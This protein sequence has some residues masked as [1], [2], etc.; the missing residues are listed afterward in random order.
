MYQMYASLEI[1]FLMEE[2]Q[3]SRESQEL[4]GGR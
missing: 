1:A 4:N 2:L 3:A